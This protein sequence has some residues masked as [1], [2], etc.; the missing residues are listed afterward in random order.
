[1]ALAITLDREHDEKPIDMVNPLNHGLI[2]T[3]PASLFFVHFAHMWDGPTTEEFAR[4]LAKALE[5]SASRTTA[6][7]QAGEEPGKDSSPAWSS[8]KPRSDILHMGL[9]I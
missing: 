5:D 2:V 9:S 6:D 1:M 3:H 8:T 7:Q 4:E